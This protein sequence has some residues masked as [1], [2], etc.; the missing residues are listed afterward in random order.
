[1]ADS[2]K[3]T[4]PENESATSIKGYE[5]VL[6]RLKEERQHLRDDIERDYKEARGYVR[7]HPEEGI[8]VAFVGGLAL[9][10][11]LGGLSRRQ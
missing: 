7:S 1:M 5:K 9:G 4:E 11:L 8:L 2:K 3:S 10:I 6:D